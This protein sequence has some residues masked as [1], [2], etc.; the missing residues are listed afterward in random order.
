MADTV[1]GGRYLVNGQ[2]VN[3]WGEAIADPQADP[4]VQAGDADFI[5][6]SI[7]DYTLDELRGLA[8]GR[9]TGYSNMNKEKLYNAFVSWSLGV[10]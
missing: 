1:P 4:E 2:W 8:K 3:A 6:G 9:I 7:D 5:L 10:S